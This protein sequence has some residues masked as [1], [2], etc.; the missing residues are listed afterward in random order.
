M[1]LDAILEGIREAGQAQIVDIQQKA[2][3]EAR[4]ILTEAQQAAGNISGQ[5][6]SEELPHARREQASIL[7]HARL[8]ALHITENASLEQVNAVIEGARE[9]LM[10][11][12]AARSYPALLSR[13]IQEALDALE[14]SLR[15]GEAIHLMADPRDRDLIEAMLKN[16]PDRVKIKYNLNTWGGVNAANEDEQVCILNTLEMRLE[17]AIPA[18]QQQITAQFRAEAGEA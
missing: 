4:R 16:L 11:A 7:Q 18:L 8:E 12:R 9:R 10:D 5:A 1:S 13:L 6:E 2:Q 14:P 15:P 17:R 3:E